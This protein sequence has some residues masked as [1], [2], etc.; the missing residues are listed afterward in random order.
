MLGLLGETFWASREAVRW[1]WLC[2]SPDAMEDGKMWE[3][4]DGLRLC[5]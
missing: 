5:V 4:R 2:R 1:S 3:V